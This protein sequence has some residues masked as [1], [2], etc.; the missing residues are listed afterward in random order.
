MI[1]YP[2]YKAAAAHVAPVYLDV[3]K[4][5]DK[6][7]DVIAEAARQ[8]VRLIAFPE[9]FI[10]G[11]PH[12]GRVVAP[13]E[14]DEFFQMLAARAIRV[15]GPELA[16]VRAVAAR[17]EIVVSMGFTEGTDVSVGCLWN[18]N[19]LIGS[20]GAILNHHRKLVPTYVEKLAYANGDGSG[21]KVSATDIGRV[22]MLICGE[23]ANPLARYTLMAQGEQVHIS[24][25]PSVAPARN[26]DGT[27][28]YDIQ[29]AIRIRAAAHSF[30]AKVYNIV[31]STPFDESARSFLGELGERT[32]ALF[33][34]GSQAVSM[35]I[36]PTGRP[37]SEV[38]SDNEGICVAEIDLSRAVPLKR[39]HDVVGYY[40]RFDIFSVSVNRS[41][42]VPIDLTGDGGQADP[43]GY[44]VGADTLSLSHP[45][46][47]LTY[48]DPAL[49]APATGNGVSAP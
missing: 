12:W 13:I 9:V 41:P 33:E 44:G 49:G 25:Y 19:V 43:V 11:Y 36:D 27:G 39:I 35:I 34:N 37:V 48:A 31:A 8:G 28:G 6:A 3:E 17:H 47:T 26:P 16:R 32:L 2:R 38:L 4:T 46:P 10:A 30:E 45:D 18:S 15:D 20:D 7:C 29:D 1:E 14:T 24:S 5:V 40:N 22:G 23:N 42:Q 21:L